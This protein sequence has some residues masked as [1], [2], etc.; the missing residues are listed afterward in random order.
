MKANR[1]KG[2]GDT[3]GGPGGSPPSLGLEDW[4]GQ[5]QAL[6]TA[7]PR[8]P[9]QRARKSLLRSCCHFSV[10]VEPCSG[11]GWILGGFCPISG[12][13]IAVS[14]LI[15]VPRRTWASS[16]PSLCRGC[17]WLVELVLWLLRELRHA[18]W[19]QVSRQWRPCAP[20]Q[21]WPFLPP[22]HSNKEQCWGWGWGV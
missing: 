13:W 15:S 11:S 20:P 10:L 16:D 21:K 12:C 7:Q 5:S 22:K 1:G 9:D 19:G 18:G 3:G 17:T 8:Q 2:A 4:T 14:A 6:R